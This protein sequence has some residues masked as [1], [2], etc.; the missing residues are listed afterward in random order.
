MRRRAGPS[1]FSTDANNPYDANDSYANALLGN[2][3]SYA[4]ALG[5]RKSN[6]LFTNTEW[7]IQDDW[8]VS[9]GCR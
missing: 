4:E 2:F 6:Y 8:K 1:V 7:F 9:R 5:R 3:D